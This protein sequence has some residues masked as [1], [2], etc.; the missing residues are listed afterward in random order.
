ME[1]RWTYSGGLDSGGIV[2]RHVVSLVRHDDLVVRFG[3]VVSMIRSVCLFVEGS[4]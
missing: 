1:W 2:A 4:G 3:L